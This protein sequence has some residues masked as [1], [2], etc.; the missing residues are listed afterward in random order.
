MTTILDMNYNTSCLLGNLKVDTALQKERVEK[1]KLK[2]VL[3]G[4]NSDYFTQK[5][6][7]KHLKSGTI[8]R[9]KRQTRDWEKILAIYIFDKGP[10]SKIY[11]ELV[12]FNNKKTQ[13][14]NLEMGKRSRYLTREAIQMANK[15][16]KRCSTL[17]V[18]GEMQIKTTM[19]FSY[20]AIRR[21]QTNTLTTPNAD[22]GVEQQELSHPL[23][24]GMQNDTDNLKTVGQ[25]LTLTAQSNSLAPWY[26]SK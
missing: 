25:F 14:N 10:V 23:L 21:L 20:T 26:L 17:Y 15:H 9:K 6:K 2:P 19:Q 5:W 13:V 24:V 3:S 12:K 8:K 11:K 1:R 4:N 18:I 22:K 16:I 7:S